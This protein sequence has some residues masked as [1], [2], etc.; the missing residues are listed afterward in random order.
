MEAVPL[1]STT[2]DDCAGALIA[3]WVTR[4]GVPAAIISD[5]GS[6]FS[7]AIW[8]SF[9]ATIGAQH[10]PTTAYPPPPLR[11]TAWWSACTAT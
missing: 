1:A 9:C 3:A 11:E 7:G 10:I 5:R 4:F 6:Q 2:A 8:R